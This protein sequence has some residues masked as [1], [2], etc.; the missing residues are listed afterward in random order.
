MKSPPR[1]NSYDEEDIS[2][3]FAINMGEAFWDIETYEPIEHKYN[4]VF[5]ERGIPIYPEYNMSIPDFFKGIIPE[6]QYLKGI[7]VID[8][9]GV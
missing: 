9:M 4:V 5:D 2:N 6:K 7:F 1:K 3:L 8:T